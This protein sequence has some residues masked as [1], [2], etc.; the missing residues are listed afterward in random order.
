MRLDCVV[1]LVWKLSG[2]GREREWGGREKMY[3]LVHKLDLRTL[4]GFGSSFGG[5]ALH[6]TYHYESLNR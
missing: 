5:V 1:L 6:A 4:S 2:W 3:T